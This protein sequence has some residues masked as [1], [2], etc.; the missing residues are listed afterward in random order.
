M[1]EYLKIYDIALVPLY[2]III[3]IIATL[4][5]RRNIEQKPYYKYFT[6]GLMVKIFAGLA[7]CSIYLFHY[8]GGDTI[9]YYLGSESLIKLAVKDFLT[10]INILFGNKSPE[11]YSVFDY[12]T[13][14]PLYYRDPN[15]FAVSRFSIP[16]YILG[17]G[18]YIGTTIIMNTI[19]YLTVWKFYKMLTKMYP[20]DYKTTAIAILFIPSVVLWSSGLLKDIYCFTAVLALFT[21]FY[22][23]FFEKKKVIWNI[24]KLLFW[25]YILVSIRPFTLYAVLVSILIWTGFNYLNKIKS[26]FMRTIVFPVVILFLWLLGSIIVLQIGSALGGRYGSYEAMMET[27]SI[28]QDDLRKEYYG[29]NSFDIGYFEP[30]LEGIMWKAPKAIVAGIFRP[31]LWEANNLLMLFSGMESI[32]LLVLISFVLIKVGPLYFFKVIYKDAFLIASLV[33]AVTFAFFVGLTTANFGALV[34][35][36]IPGLPFLLIILFS[37]RNNWM[38]K[39]LASNFVDCRFIFRNY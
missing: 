31:F 24:I 27:A 15:A 20:K 11:S 17:L 22:N 16:F 19:M 12:K 3:F 13:G 21:I 28:I 2:I 35:Y 10:F 9:Y 1:T 37:I 32:I 38:Q 39:K 6:A 4:V 5:T 25:S 7:F 23:L 26:G 14:F 8:Q 34:R 29:G 33:F 30:T 36:R 18:S